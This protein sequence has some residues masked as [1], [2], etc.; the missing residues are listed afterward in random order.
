MLVTHSVMTVIMCW[1]N[2]WMYS[3]NYLC[4]GVTTDEQ[5]ARMY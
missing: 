3:I 4:K 1:G 5:V 2:Y